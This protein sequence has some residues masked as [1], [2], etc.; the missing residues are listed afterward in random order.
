MRVRVYRN[1]HKKAY[2]VQAR[3]HSNQWRVIYTKSYIHLTNVEFHLIPSG[4]NRV[5]ETKQKNVHAFIIGDLVEL[6]QINFSDCNR[7]TY[8]P[9]F[10][11]W[12]VDTKTGERVN[13]ASEVFLT[14]KGVYYR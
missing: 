11:D 8:N 6:P 14:N 13:K 5:R 2:S 4:Q 12:F 3:N 1:L 9:H 7:L 10:N